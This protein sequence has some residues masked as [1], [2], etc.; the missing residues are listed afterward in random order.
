M[1]H[2]P[3]SFFSPTTDKGRRVRLWALPIIAGMLLLTLGF[4]SGVLAAPHD[5]PTIYY[6]CVNNSS[7]TIHMTDVNG[8]CGNNETKISWNQVGPA[9]PAGPT[10]PTGSQGPAGPTGPQGPAGPSNGFSANLSAD[11]LIGFG[12]FTTLVTLNLPASTPGN[13]Y[14]LSGYVTLQSNPNFQ[15][16]VTCQISGPSDTPSGTTVVIPIVVGPAHQI[17]EVSLTHTLSN[18]PGGDVSLQCVLTAGNS[19]VTALSLITTIPG[20]NRTAIATQLTA[21]QVGSL[22]QS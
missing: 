16:E 18:F 11:A 17:T 20:T 7:G 5:N 13:N 19:G 21:V 3:K 6:A 4:A 22:T 15:T 12:N 9:G 14:L 8:T 2:W 1:K 10:G